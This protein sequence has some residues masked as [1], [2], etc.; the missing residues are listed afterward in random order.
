MGWVRPLALARAFTILLPVIAAASKGAPTQASPQAL[1]DLYRQRHFVAAETGLAGIRDWPAF[2]TEAAGRAQAW[3]PDAGAAF[4]L[5]A[6]HALFLQSGG[7]FRV[8]GVA[9]EQLLEL[10]F[11]RIER[12]EVHR[13]FALAWHR[14]RFALH[15]GFGPET[16]NIENRD[17]AFAQRALAHIPDEP[18][19]Q[20][21]AAISREQQL[22]EWLPTIGIEVRR[23]IPIRNPRD[24]DRVLA[25][26]AVFALM[27]NLAATYER[28]SEAADL[29]G[30]PMLRAGVMKFLNDDAP[31]AD[32]LPY[33]EQ[34]ARD[35]DPWVAYL[36]RVYSGRLHL[37]EARASLAVEAFRDASALRPAAQS[38]R[39]GLAAALLLDRR[40][41][42]AVDE[43]VRLVGR[44]SAVNDPWQQ[45]P[46]GAYRHLPE[47]LQAMREFI[48]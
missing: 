34:A 8:G 5:E 3:P 23:V 12:P 47:W 39:I 30:E 38:A 43:A 40:Q 19:I 13:P 48:Q 4:V 6:L 22:H 31:S 7:D 26:N 10:G 16:A 11:D 42:D 36:G 46:Y 17:G 2:A 9:Q 29:E 45:Y 15:Q 35:S 24:R 1:F 37:A 21:L 44:S 18:E 27:E 14:V 28:L 41:M 33:F 20:W 32:A 25:R